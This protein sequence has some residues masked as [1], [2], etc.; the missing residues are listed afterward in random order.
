MISS[1]AHNTL[2]GLVLIIGANC[3]CVLASIRYGFLAVSFGKRGISGKVY[4]LVEGSVFF[5]YFAG[6][7]CRGFSERL[8][9]KLTPKWVMVATTAVLS[10]TCAMS[11]VA[12]Y[13][14]DNTVFIIVSAA[15][16]VLFGFFNF[17]RS[18]G[19]LDLLKSTFPNNFD[20]VNGVM[21]TAMFAGHCIGQYVGVVLYVRFGYKAPFWF[22]TSCMVLTLILYIIVLPSTPTIALSKADEKTQLLSQGDEET[23]DE[24]TKGLTKYI[25][26]PM[27][28]C[29]MI[30][31]VYGYLQVSTTPYLLEK[32][33]IPLSLGGT[34]LIAL[35]VGIA[36]GSLFSGMLGQSGVCNTYTQM[37]VGAGMVAL[38]L[39]IMFP[40]PAIPFIYNNIPY[41]VYP[42][43]ILAGMGDPFVT[44]PTLRA[45]SELQV[46]VKG[47]CSGR[48]QVSL[49]G[50]WMMC[51]WGAVYSGA[52]ISGV[53]LEY[54]SYDQSAYVL[55]AS[56]CLS[57]I[58]CCVMN[59]MERRFS[60]VAVDQT[61][62]SDK[63][64]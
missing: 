25:F 33:S 32:F 38:G 41:I 16:R 34:V 24:D 27:A 54:L 52:L 5:G 1:S 63:N 47:S 40:N 44:L 42:T 15:A 13:S 36:A 50:V 17:S 48:N 45:M 58:L 22:T 35:S 23:Q 30:N 46:R 56:C 21:Q 8:V 43:V 37:T 26:F 60:Y 14:T 2:I 6:F 49:F 39:L 53:M 51:T 12:D 10:V 11:G 62:V 9:E 3:V 18:I 7:L 20:F 57:M 4:G 31:C 29:M 59:V 28:A 19:S 55:V 64:W 61:S